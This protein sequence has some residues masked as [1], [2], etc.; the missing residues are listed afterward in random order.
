MQGLVYI[1]HI[2]LQIHVYICVYTN[3][4]AHNNELNIHQYITCAQISLSL[5]EGMYICVFRWKDESILY[6]NIYR[7]MYICVYTNVYVNNNELNT[8]QFK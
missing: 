5:F 3:I 1:L 2:Y 6:I 7:Y 8:H 4:Y